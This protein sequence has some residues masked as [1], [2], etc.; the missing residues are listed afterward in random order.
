MKENTIIREEIVGYVLFIG[1]EIN[2][3]NVFNEFACPCGRGTWGEV[4]VY[5]HVDPRSRTVLFYPLRFP[6]IDG[7]K[8]FFLQRLNETPTPRGRKIR[9][10]NSPNADCYRVQVKHERGRYTRNM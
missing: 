4:V 7:G 2:P 6:D 1:P 8:K 5:L 10:S 9:R 3:P